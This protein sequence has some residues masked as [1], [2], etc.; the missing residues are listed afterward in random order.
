MAMQRIDRRYIKNHREKSRKI[1][2]YLISESGGGKELT[3]RKNKI[4][5]QNREMQYI[6]ERLFINYSF[7]YCQI[8]FFLAARVM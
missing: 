2:A 4:N 7:S 8:I 6:T 3:S 5:L 1:V